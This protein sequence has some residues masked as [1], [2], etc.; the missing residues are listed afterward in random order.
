MIS[1]GS[2]HPVD[3]RDPSGFTAALAVS[4]I[5][6][7]EPAAELPT[8]AGAADLTAALAFDSLRELP[9][10][11]RLYG[12]TS[13]MLLGALLLP[14]ELAGGNAAPA[15]PDAFCGEFC[16]CDCIRSCWGDTAML[17]VGW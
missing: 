12:P 16:P 11:L 6:D 13:F 5:A 2:R 15:A 3:H 1:K 4:S 10:L 9:M 17:K 8:I 14:V 7:V